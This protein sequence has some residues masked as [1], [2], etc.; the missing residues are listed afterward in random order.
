MK[1]I[2][3]SLNEFKQLAN[4]LKLDWVRDNNKLVKQ[5]GIYNGE[6]VEVYCYSDS[7]SKW[8]NEDWEYESSVN[9]SF[10]I[11]HQVVTLSLKDLVV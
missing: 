4:Y 8:T 7:F 9:P 3:I 2:T 6:I 1:K 5:V 11:N 10:N